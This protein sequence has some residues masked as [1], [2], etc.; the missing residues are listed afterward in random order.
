MAG[1]I[2][3]FETSSYTSPLFIPIYKFLCLVA[4][5]QKYGGRLG[6]GEKQTIKAI[7][8]PLADHYPGIV[9]YETY[10]DKMVKADYQI[11]RMKSWRGDRAGRR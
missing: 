8:I 1:I 2:I 10:L 9:A 6:A 3:I 11:E 7:Y 5:E 4:E